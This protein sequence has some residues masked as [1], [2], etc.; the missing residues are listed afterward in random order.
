[1][2]TEQSEPEEREA[3]NN[4]H[5]SGGNFK[6]HFQQLQRVN[7]TVASYQLKTTVTNNGSKARVSDNFVSKMSKYDF[8]LVL[9]LSY[10]NF[11]TKH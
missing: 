5:T 11:I 9:Y 4:K 1:M 8:R 2:I 7:V 10:Y 6:T 3:P